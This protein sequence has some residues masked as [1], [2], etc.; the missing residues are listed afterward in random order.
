[1]DNQTRPSASQS[2]NTGPEEPAQQRS[3][4]TYYISHTQHMT[5]LQRIAMLDLL[6]SYDIELRPEGKERAPAS[7][8]NADRYRIY[9]RQSP[10]DSVCYCV[11]GFVYTLMSPMNGDTRYENYKKTGHGMWLSASLRY[12]LLSTAARLKMQV[13]TEVSNVPEPSPVL[14]S[15]ALN[16][17]AKGD[18]LA[19]ALATNTAEQ[20]SDAD[21]ADT[22][23]TAEKGNG[24]T[25]NPAADKP[26]IDAPRM[27]RIALRLLSNALD[28]GLHVQLLQAKPIELCLW[29]KGYRT[30]VVGD[31]PVKLILEYINLAEKNA[32]QLRPVSGVAVAK[33]PEEVLAI[34]REFREAMLFV[35]MCITAQADPSFFEEGSPLFDKGSKQDK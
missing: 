27:Q 25:P 11:D 31:S 7:H 18:A 33:T 16:F 10:T 22:A 17:I 20:S 28:S 21:T 19:R 2:A 29:F 32:L 34:T 5:M 4:N 12:K 26:G 3:I 30:N 15:N 23:D 9:H 24:S 8:N 35:S 14:T 1:M 13:P 6:R